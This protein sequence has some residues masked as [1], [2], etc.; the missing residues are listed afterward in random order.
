MEGLKD[1]MKKLIDFLAPLG[2]VVM[3]A[4]QAWVRFGKHLPGGPDAWLV[5]LRSCLREQIAQSSETKHF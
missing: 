2:I 4:S 3:V 5:S 1:A